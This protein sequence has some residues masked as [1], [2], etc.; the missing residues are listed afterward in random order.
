MENNTRSFEYTRQVLAKLD[1][2]ARN[3]I[4]RLGGNEG[5]VKV[6]DKMKVGYGINGELS[7]N[8]SEESFM[9]GQSQGS[10]Q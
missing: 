4:E 3:E 2:Q 6:L 1:W 5:L 7:S 8:R 9:P 10:L